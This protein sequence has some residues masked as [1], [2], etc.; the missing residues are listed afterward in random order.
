MHFGAEV[1]HF[2]AQ[3][4]DLAPAHQQQPE[5]FRRE[6]FGQ[7]VEGTCPHGLHGGVDGGVGCHYH[8]ARG[9]SRRQKLWEKIQAGFAA[10]AEIDKGEVELFLGDCVQRRRTRANFGDLVLLAFQG[11]AKCPPKAGF[12]VNQKKVH[13][14]VLQSHG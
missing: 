1:G 13:G 2:L 12:V 9:R 6:G 3:A 5:L 10:Q 11:Q 14:G 7:V 8:V 4:I